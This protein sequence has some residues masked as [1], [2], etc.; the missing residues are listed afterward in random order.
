M[1]QVLYN[2]ALNM[3]KTNL[4]FFWESGPKYMAGFLSTK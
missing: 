4:N 3:E 1:P 2:F